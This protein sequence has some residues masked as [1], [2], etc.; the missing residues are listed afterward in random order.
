MLLIKE[1]PDK[2][3][4]K[5][6]FKDDDDVSAASVITLLSMMKASS[7]IMLVIDKF[8]SVKNLSHSRFTA[9]SILTK[10]D[11]GLFPNELA[12]EMGISRATVSTIIKGLETGGLAEISK[13]DNDGR[14][15][16]IVITEKGRTLYDELLP[17]YFAILSSAATG[18]GKKDMKTVAETMQTVMDNLAKLK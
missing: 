8:F 3:A 13:A 4:I 7:D 6:V 5:K 18:L 11:T 9:M 14:M 12:D 17:E 15:K 1:L 10:A 2:K 16:K